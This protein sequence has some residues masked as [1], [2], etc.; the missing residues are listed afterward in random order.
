MT[1]LEHKKNANVS[2]FETERNKFMKKAATHTPKPCVIDTNLG[3]KWQ[4][5]MVWTKRRVY[6]CNNFWESRK[7][8]WNLDK[9]LIED[10]LGNRKKDY[11]FKVPSRSMSS[12]MRL[13]PAFGLLQGN[14]HFKRIIALSLYFKSHGYSQM[15]ILAGQR[16][17]KSWTSR[18]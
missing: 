18:I 8:C 6:H 13:F 11:L 5:R 7:S 1:R 4:C 15:S 16:H 10:I 9:T 3:P 14:F 2:G 17:S 12:N